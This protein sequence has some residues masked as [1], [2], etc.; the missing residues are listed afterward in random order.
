MDQLD[1][2]QSQ[3]AQLMMLKSRLEHTRQVSQRCVVLAS[4]PNMAA[5][6]IS[7]TFYSLWFS[8][9]DDTPPVCQRLDSVTR[10]QRKIFTLFYVSPAY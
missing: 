1:M 9:V 10:L 2:E 7:Q 4:L 3:V 6:T 8:P 5:A